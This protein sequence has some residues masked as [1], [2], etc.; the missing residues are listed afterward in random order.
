MS[1]RH[2]HVSP[3]RSPKLV[4]NLT[5]HQLHRM[6]SVTF[7]RPL[8]GYLKVFDSNQCVDVGVSL[9]SS[10]P[11][12]RKP[13]KIL[14]HLNTGLSVFYTGDKYNDINVI[15]DS[16]AYDGDTFRRQCQL[17][18]EF[19]RSLGLDNIVR[20]RIPMPT[21]D[22]TTIYDVYLDHLG[23]AFRQI[24][25]ANAYQW[26]AEDNI[27]WAFCTDRDKKPEAIL[28]YSYVGRLDTIDDVLD[29]SR[30]I[31]GKLRLDF[32]RVDVAGVVGAALDAVSQAAAAKG[33][34]LRVDVGLGGG[35]DRAAVG[36]AVRR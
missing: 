27:D 5:Q 36:L 20:L 35:R 7:A 30:I 23:P 26:R 31:T 12:Y 14:Y 2:R 24:D 25:F 22:L 28:G 9:S 4:F 32:E 18:I 33:V 16:L 21:D 13:Y 6:Q 1:Y 29:V 19:H 3:T 15:S 10:S 34:D 17:L 11:M 8:P